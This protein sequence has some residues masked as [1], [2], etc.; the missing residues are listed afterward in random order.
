MGS[1]MYMAPEVFKQSYNADCDVWSLGICLYLL[2]SGRPPFEGSDTASIFRRG[3]GGGGEGEG[4]GG[5]G[6]EERG[7]MTH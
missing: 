5:G 1:A 4:G 2:L 7:E 3:R 6:E